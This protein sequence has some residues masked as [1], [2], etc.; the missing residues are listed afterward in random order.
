MS[1]LS[2]GVDFK[3]EEL[4]MLQ[5]KANYSGVSVSALLRMFIRNYTPD[6]KAIVANS[7]CVNCG[8]VNPQEE[9]LDTLPVRF[10]LP[11]ECVIHVT[12]VPHHKCNSCNSLHGDLQLISTIEQ[13]VEHVVEKKINKRDEMIPTVISL[14]ELLKGW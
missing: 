11:E 2:L 5:L 3:E 9:V 4:L 12:D 14:N 8:G 1:K 10:E 6:R 7:Y 13:V